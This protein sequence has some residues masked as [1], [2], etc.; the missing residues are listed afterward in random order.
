MSTDDAS[1]RLDALELAFISLISQLKAD[2]FDPAA[3]RTRLRALAVSTTE[4]SGDAQ[5]AKALAH[6]ERRIT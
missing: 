1:A 3:F 5:V 6:L 4:T 2:G